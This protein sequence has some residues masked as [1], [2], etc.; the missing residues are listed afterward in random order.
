MSL[1]AK[2]LVDADCRPRATVVPVSTDHEY[3]PYHI[4]LHQCSGT[5][6][7]T[8]PSIK[9][10]VAT[11]EHDVSVDVKDEHNNEVTVTLKN[12][13]KCGGGCAS[14]CFMQDHD[15]RCPPPSTPKASNRAG[16]KGEPIN[17][18]IIHSTFF[19]IAD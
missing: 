4:V 15:C 2:K 13:T 3:K 8:S 19:L 7:R 10:C 6:E 17:H 11:E 14:S 16:L 5:Y 12:H 9:R 18:A 1:E